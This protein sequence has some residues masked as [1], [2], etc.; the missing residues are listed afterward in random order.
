MSW[1]V[2]LICIQQTGSS[3]VVSDRAYG[4]LVAYA[5]T[6]RLYYPDAAALGT[7]VATCSLDLARRFNERFANVSRG[8]DN[9]LST[10]ITKTELNEV[11]NRYVTDVHTK[12]A[13]NN[14]MYLSSSWDVYIAK[15]N[16]LH[17]NVYNVRT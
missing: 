2:H 4:M 8:L 13:I 7:S 5:E 3:D 16:G 6:A 17:T 11:F 12:L 15:L 9:F 14:D 1:I 10:D